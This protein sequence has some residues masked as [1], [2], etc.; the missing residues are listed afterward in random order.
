V[1]GGEFLP[2]SPVLVVAGPGDEITLPFIRVD[3]RLPE[4]KDWD[5]APLRDREFLFR[6]CLAGVGERLAEVLPQEQ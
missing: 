6:R 4:D 1:V 5:P 2:E 3:A